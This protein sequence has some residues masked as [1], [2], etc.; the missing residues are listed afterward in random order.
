MVSARATPSDARPTRPKSGT[1]LAVF[2]SFFFSPAPDDPVGAAP[3]SVAGPAFGAGGFAAP[4]A[5][6]AATAALACFIAATVVT[7]HACLV[8][9]SVV[10]AGAR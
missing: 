6:F 9:R 8:T 1:W 7:D 4:A 5:G 3:V 2:G 10:R